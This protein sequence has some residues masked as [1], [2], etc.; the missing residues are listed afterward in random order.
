MERVVG[1]T[2]VGHAELRPTSVAE[3]IMAMPALRTRPWTIEQVE[4]L[5]EQR[6]GYTPR[7]ELVDGELLVTPGPSNRHQRIAFE[8]AILLREYVG[9]H[10]LG[11]VL[12]GPG[13]VRLDSAS[14]FEPDVFVVP[15]VNGR[16]QASAIPVTRVLLAIEVLSPS[17]ARHDRITKRRYFQRHG[18]P[19]YWVVDGEARAFECWRPGDERAMLVDDRLT[20][21]PHDAAAPLQLDVASFFDAVADEE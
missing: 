4:A 21:N 10:R 17:S 14:Y 5:M 20:W 13:A 2:M 11:E 1:P 7:Y 8:L 12:L 16:R 3:Q 9:R 15:A 18:V 6:D 19:D